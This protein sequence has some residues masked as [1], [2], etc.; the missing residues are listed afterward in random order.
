MHGG[1]AFAKALAF[2][3]GNDDSGMCTH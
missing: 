1:G 3:N 2:P